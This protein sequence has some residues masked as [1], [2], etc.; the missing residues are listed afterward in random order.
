MSEDLEDIHKEALARYDTGWQRDRSNQERA[1]EDLRFLAD[2]DNGQWDSAIKKQR[3]A[4]G[5]PVLTVNKCSQFVRQITGDIRQLRPAVHVMPVDDDASEEIAVKVL[6]AL[7]RYIETRSDAKGAYFSAADQMVACGIGHIRVYT[8][9][10]SETTF[11]Q[12]ICIEAIDDGVN[13][14]WDPDAIKPTRADA[15][16]CCVPV[17]MTKSAAKEKW[18]DKQWDAPLQRPIPDYLVNWWTDDYVRVTEYWRKVPTKKELALF[19]NGSIVDLTDD[20]DGAKRADADAAGARIEKR[21]AYKVERYVISAQEILEGPEEWPGSMIPIV[22]ML[23]EEIKI[24]RE[25]VRRG[26]IRQLQ[27]VQR[28][29]NYAISADAEAVALQPKA[30]FIG[31]RT[32]FEEFEDEWDS[33]NSKN[34]PY[35]RYTPD[36]E[37]GGGPPQRQPPPV[38]SVGIREL[39]QVANGDFNAVTGIYPASLGQASNESSGKAILARQREGD[40]GTYHFIDAFGR[41]IKRVG[42]IVIDL[43]GHVYD[44]ARTLRITGEDG[45]LDTLKINQQMIDP[46]GDGIATMVMNDITVGAYEVVVEMGP[47]YSTKRE[48][49]RD[50]MQSLMQ[51]LGPQAAVL[52]AD[53]YAKSQDWPLADKIARRARLTLPPAIQQMEAQEDGEPPPQLPPQQPPPP[54]PEQQ[55]EAAKLQQEA[56]K[57][58]AE[59]ELTQQKLGVEQQ[60]I[61]ADMAKIN[62]DL[63]MARMSHEQARM[64]HEQKMAGMMP[65]QRIDVLTD[66][67][68][69]L[70]AIVVQI[71]DHVDGGAEPQAEVGGAGV[72][73]VPPPPIDLPPAPATPPPNGAGPQ[74]SPFPG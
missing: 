27:D 15:M 72:S 38:S 2:A 67:V 9:Y 64:G 44:T 39:M 16:W 34:W 55:L 26:I 18:P 52:F 58:Q 61:A 30:P 19:P 63:E 56:G 1:Y 11:N 73:Q 69:R 8:E 35:L 45:K 13:V 50:G 42:E 12:E 10:A 59:G 48:E 23:G 32:N 74:V 49:A 31:T 22:P 47:S 17:D 41:V 40:T 7:L 62:A 20:D 3:V 71:A 36:R 53:L 5:R 14:V 66:A 43:R 6:P 51:A 37:N 60:R 4:D 57:A 21:D 28:L 24:G 54:T 25:I 29:Y 70:Q 65:D 68:A 33:A 46:N